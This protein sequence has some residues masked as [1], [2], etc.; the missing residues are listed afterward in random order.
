MSSYIV[1]TF[2]FLTSQALSSKMEG[3]ESLGHLG[4]ESLGHLGGESL[5]MRLGSV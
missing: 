5:G 2:Q 1:C 3:G 4:G